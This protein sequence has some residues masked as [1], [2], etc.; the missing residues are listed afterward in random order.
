[1]ADLL[2]TTSTERIAVLRS[3]LEYWAAVLRF[4]HGLA[5]ALDLASGYLS[6]RAA[7]K[8]SKLTNQMAECHN[9]ILG[10]LPNE[11]NNVS[12]EQLL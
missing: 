11:E 5:A 3:D 4:G 9:R 6:G 1:M 8:R 12:E 7:S 10:Y 2:D